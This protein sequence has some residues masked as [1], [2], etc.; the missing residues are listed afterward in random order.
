MS[1]PYLFSLLFTTSLPK[2]QQLVSPPLNRV[3]TST[4]VSVSFMCFSLFPIERDYCSLPRPS[5]PFV[6][7]LFYTSPPPRLQ[8][9]LNQFLPFPQVASIS[10]LGAD[11]VR[12]PICRFYLFVLFVFQSWPFVAE[13]LIVSLERV[14][15]F[16]L[17]KLVVR[18]LIN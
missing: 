6:C 12:V 15:E 5:P 13:N 1:A 16:C 10:R 4:A 17:V 9:S 7:F 3:S 11:L 18:F 8:C 14:K 2:P